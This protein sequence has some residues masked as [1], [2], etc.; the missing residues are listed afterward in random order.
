[1]ISKIV[2][3]LSKMVNRKFNGVFLTFLGCFFRVWVTNRKQNRG[4]KQGGMR[5]RS[6]LCET[7]FNDSGGSCGSFAGQTEG[8]KTVHNDPNRS[9]LGVICIGNTGV[10]T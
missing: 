6:G 8:K 1:M 4:R 7:I 2:K 3:T 9:R 5:G 10:A